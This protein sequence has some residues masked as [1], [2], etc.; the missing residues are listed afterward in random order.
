MLGLKALLLVNKW[1]IYLTMTDTEEQ[2]LSFIDCCI[3]DDPSLVVPADEEQLERLT[4]I[5]GGVAARLEAT[6]AQGSD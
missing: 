3:E 5:L 4:K 1:M 6:P 2:F